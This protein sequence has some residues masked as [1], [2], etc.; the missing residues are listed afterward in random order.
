MNNK[1][2]IFFLLISITLNAQFKEQLN[3]EV[4]LINKPLKPTLIYPYQ[5]SKTL[6]FF[7]SLAIPGLGEYYVNRFD[8][9]KYFLMAEGGLWLT[10]YG[11]GYYG[12]IQRENYISFAK[13]NGGVEPAGKDE[14]FWS[15]IGSYMSVDDFNEERLL[16]RQ[17]NSVY[18]EKTHY[19]Y[20]RTNEDRKKYR[21]LWLSS[22]SAFNNKQFPI[23]FIIINHI[24]SA[25]NASLLASKYNEQG[26]NSSLRIIPEFGVNFNFEPQLRVSF[27]KRF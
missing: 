7:L 11:F 23:A 16:N 3:Q 14:N 9:G 22:E 2:V 27:L 26:E 18:D 5:K 21:N 6:A 20:W 4:N 10:L 1:L 8:V 12:R 19:W 25:I 13:I 17:Y 24:A 15:I